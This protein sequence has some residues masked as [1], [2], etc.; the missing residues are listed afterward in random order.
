MSRMNAPRY[1]PTI[2]VLHSQLAIHGIAE[3]T[4]RFL[5][6]FPLAEAALIGVDK[7]GS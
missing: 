7:T 6:I 5:I 4:R 2:F 1:S 3:I